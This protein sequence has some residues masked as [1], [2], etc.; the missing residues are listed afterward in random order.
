M[1][2]LISI[3]QISPK[4]PREEARVLEALAHNLEVITGRR[5]ALPDELP[6][7]ATLAD[8]INKVNELRALLQG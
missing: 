7:S 5:G 3:P 8:V 4:T 1:S 6:A 2:R